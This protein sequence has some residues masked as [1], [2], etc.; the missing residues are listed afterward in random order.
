MTLGEKIT[1]LRHRLGISQRQLADRCGVTQATLSRAES[2]QVRQLRAGT[3]KR[4]AEALSVSVDDL[5]SRKPEPSPVSRS[6]SIL[7][8]LVARLQKFPAEK[9]MA[10]ESYVDFVEKQG[11][12]RG[13]AS[14]RKSAPV[15]PT[16]RSALPAE[17]TD[18]VPPLA[19]EHPLWGSERLSQHLEA[20]GVII[21]SSKVHQVLCVH[22]LQT[23]S[24]RVARLLEDADTKQVK[25]RKEQISD[26]EEFDPRFR[27]RRTIGSAPGALLVQ[28][29]CS[30]GTVDTLGDRQEARVCAY[31]VVDTCTAFA[32]A[33]LFLKDHK[34]HPE[35]DI[36]EKQVL[37]AFDKWG[38]S[39]KKVLMHSPH[40]S[41]PHRAYLADRGVRYATTSRNNGFTDAFERDLRKGFCRRAFD[42]AYPSLEALQAELCRWLEEYNRTPLHGFPNLGRSPV[43]HVGEF[44]SRSKIT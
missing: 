26:I 34:T 15:Q 33:L 11:R 36:L 5:L 32:F 38:L 2:G 14:R 18:Q 4:L 44:L 22:G 31:T 23:R 25:L 19:L 43:E 40:S 16:S 17:V 29:A 1:D 8:R 28:D 10:V 12:S 30:L 9:L 3:L 35:I 7:G 39:A 13:T 20:Q 42:R 27:E 24:Q 6:Q 41:H 21:S 37:P